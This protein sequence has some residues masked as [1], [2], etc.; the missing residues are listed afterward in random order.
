MSSKWNNH[1]RDY[2]NKHNVSLKTAM[3]EAKSSYHNQSSTSSHGRK[4]DSKGRFL[5][6]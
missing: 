4:R 5:K 1:V 3:K 2:M 6:Y